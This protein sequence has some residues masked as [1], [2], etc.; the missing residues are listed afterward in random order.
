MKQRIFSTFRAFA[1]AIFIAAVSFSGAQSA[2]TATNLFSG[3]LNK[4]GVCVL[5]DCDST[6]VNDVVANS[7]YLVYARFSSKTAYDNVRVTQAALLGTRMY[8]EYCPSTAT[9]TQATVPFPTH[10]ADVLV[11]NNTTVPDA[12][13]LRATVP[14]GKFYR[15]S[16]GSGGSITATTVK[17][18]PSSMADQIGVASF[19]ND[20]E[21]KLPLM[22]RFINGPLAG[23][24]DA[25]DICQGQ[26]FA[27]QS[28]GGTKTVPDNY[29][30]SVFRSISSFN[31]QF[32]WEKDRATEWGLFSTGIPT[33]NYYL[34][35]SSNGFNGYANNS[36][37][38]YNKLGAEVYQMTM[39]NIPAD[40]V[41][42]KGAY[43]KDDKCLIVMRKSGLGN[44]T[45]TY[46]DAA[47]QEV[48]WQKD[49]DYL[50]ENILVNGDYFYY[51]SE[52][53]S[54]VGNPAGNAD[55]TDGSVG[56]WRGCASG[57][58]WISGNYIVAGNKVH[59]LSTGNL[60]TTLIDT[61][62]TYS[63]GIAASVGKVYTGSG[64]D[65]RQLLSLANGA[66][67]DTGVWSQDWCGG[68][69]VSP[70][71]VFGQS[72]RP[73]SFETAA[74]NSVPNFDQKS[75]CWQ[76]VILGNGGAF[77][78]DF[79]CSCQRSFEGFLSLT[80]GDD[81][82]DFSYDPPSSEKLFQETNFSTISSPLEVLATD[83]STYRQNVSRSGATVAN[84]GTSVDITQR[85]IGT[86]MQGAEPTAPVTAGDFVFVADDKGRVVAYSATSGSVVWSTAVSGAVR[87]SPTVWDGRLYIGS[88]DGFAYC[89]EA[90]TG[91]LLW[92]FMAGPRNRKIMAYDKL[93]S[94]WP[95]NTGIVVLEPAATGL[96]VPAA[97]FVAGR[98]F[99]DGVYAYAVN[100]LTGEQL[101]RQDGLGVV[102]G[103]TGSEAM[104]V[105][106]IV[107]VGQGY[108][109]VSGATQG[110]GYYAAM[111]LATGA[112]KKNMRT[113][114][115]P[116]GHFAGFFKNKYM[117]AGARS[118]Y[119][120]QD[121][122][123]GGYAR[124]WSIWSKATNGVTDVPVG[125]TYSQLPAAWDDTLTLVTYSGS[126]HWFDAL[127][128]TLFETS[129]DTATASGPIQ[130]TGW[131]TWNATATTRAWATPKVVTHCRGY[132]LAGDVAIAVGNKSTAKEN[133]AGITYK[134][135]PDF[136]FTERSD[137]YLFT[138]D[139]VTGAPLNEVALPGE[140]L[141]NGLAVD[142]SGNIVISFLDGKIGLYKPQA[143][144]N[145]PLVVNAGTGSGTYL[146]SSA[147]TITAAAPPVGMEFDQWTGD[148]GCLADKYSSTTTLLLPRAATAVTA[149]Y[150]ATG[151]TYAITVSGGTGGGSFP[152]GSAPAIAAAAPVAGKL[153]QK[154]TVS[155]NGSCMDP[156]AS[157][158]QFVVGAGNATVTATYA[159]VIPSDTQSFFVDFGPVITP[160][161][162]GVRWNNVTDGNTGVKVANLLDSQGTSS[163]LSLSLSGNWETTSDYQDGS[164]AGTLIYPVSVLN[165]YIAARYQMSSTTW[166]G[167]ITLSNLALEQYNIKVYYSFPK[168]GKGVLTWAGSN[169][170]TGNC[171]GAIQ[172]AAT[173][174][175]STVT[176][177]YL[178]EFNGV[179]PATTG[180][181]FDVDVFSA[182][183]GSVAG[184]N[185]MEVTKVSD[186]TWKLLIDFGSNPSPAPATD[187]NYWN[188]LS[189]EVVKINSAV[190]SDNSASGVKLEIPYYWHLNQNGSTTNTAY[191]DNA[192]SD[193]ITTRFMFT[194]GYPNYTVHKDPGVVSLS[195]LSA[196]K[197]YDFKIYTLGGWYTGNIKSV[198]SGTTPVGTVSHYGQDWL[199]ANVDG[200]VGSVD[201]SIDTTTDTSRGAIAVMEIISKPP[202]DVSAPAFESG[203]PYAME[204]TA[205]SVRIVVKGNESGTVY[206][207]VR[208]AGDSV[209]KPMTGEETRNASTG[210]FALSPYET[211]VQISGLVPEKA[212]EICLVAEDAAETPNLQAS[213]TAVPVTTLA[214][215]ALTVNN[216]RGSGTYAAGAGVRIIANKGVTGKVFDH[217]SASAGTLAD[218]N[219]S[220]TTFV[221]PGS[222]ASVTPVYR[223]ATT[224]TVSVNGG[225]GGGVYTEG[226]MIGI[227]AAP[228]A[229]GKVFDQW[230]GDVSG[231]DVYS[232]NIAVP[233]SSSRNL[234]ATY[235]D[236]K[237]RVDFG[238]ATL[239]STR[240][241]NNI[242][243][244]QTAAW[245]LLDNGENAS[246]HT[247][248]T[249]YTSTTGWYSLGNSGLNPAVEVHFPDSASKD[250]FQTQGAD[251]AKGTGT[252]VI[253][254]FD[255]SKIYDF[256]VY[257]CS[258]DSTY[259]RNTVVSV[260]GSTQNIN[261]K[262]NLNTVLTFTGITPVNGV[263]TITMTPQEST[264]GTP[265]WKVYMN[266]LEFYETPDS[267]APA[268]ASAPAV[269]P[270]S[271]SA[272]VTLS[273]NE[274][275]IVSYALFASG[276]AAPTPAAVKAGTGALVIG[277]FA[278][279]KNIADTFALT[280]L[281]SNTHYDLYLVAED[282]WGN[283]QG[284]VTKVSFQT[285]FPAPTVAATNV[286][287]SSIT[288]SSLTANWTRG[289]GARCLVVIRQ[290]GDVTA[291]L[292]V[293]GQSYTASQ[294]WASKGSNLGNGCYAIYDGT[295][296]SVSLTG[297]DNPGAV[298]MVT[299]Y[300]YNGVGSLANYLTVDA[301]TASGAMAPG[302]A[303]V[304]Q[305]AS[306]VDAGGNVTLSVS[307]V[308]GNTYQWYQG[309]SG[310][311]S[312][313]VSGATAASYTTP[314]L[315]ADASYWVKVTTVGGTANS[316]TAF[317][318]VK[319]PVWVAYHATYSGA[320]SANTTVG[321]YEVATVFNLKRS[322]N[323]ATNNATIQYTR[324][325]GTLMARTDCVAGPSSGTDAY[326]LFNGKVVVGP[327]AN[328]VSNV[329]KTDIVIAGLSSSKR[330][331]LAIYATRDASNVTAKNKYTL[332][333]VNAST[334]AHSA[335]CT[336][337]T[338]GVWS[339]PTG[340]GS[341]T[342]GRLIR[343]TGIQ[344]TSDRISVAVQAD[345]SPNYTVPQAISITEEYTAPA[346]AAISAQPVGS[347]IASGTTASMSVTATGTGLQYQWFEGTSGDTAHPVA[348][349]MSASLTTPA[350]S[351]TTS[352]WV[353]VLNAGGSVD[354]AAAT[355]AVAS[356]TGY[357]AWVATHSLAGGNALLSAS[358]AGDGVTNLV[359][360]ALG[361]APDAAA[362]Q[363]LPY[364]EV[365]G[366]N[367]TL[368]FRKGKTVPGSWQYIVQSS[369]NLTV[370]ND[371]MVA[372]AAAITA[373]A[374]ASD[375]DSDTYKASIPLSNGSGGKLFLRLK[376]IAP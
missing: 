258:Y 372:T 7:D 255:D 329:G 34:H 230:T 20:W 77:Y 42:Y 172:T 30:P 110:K 300:E 127:D 375:A 323:G 183:S 365:E 10:Y 9:S 4:R 178:M 333:T 351:A 92:K 96:G 163:A 59:A 100:A 206:Y 229:Y 240:G 103:Y 285:T 155:G 355:V 149:T 106:T 347:S 210:S 354:S 252:I 279:T 41:F 16:G 217:W 152:V 179:T 70:R 139:K 305:T 122:L 368:R 225:S 187:G 157:T 184:I 165:D 56:G 341:Q 339:V 135:A 105:N 48:I 101:W 115:S 320:H 72:G 39:P 324:T 353:R 331:T 185:A 168:L 83:W 374:V 370:W 334:P 304:A 37:R 161:T 143:R 213:P 156:F 264:G 130:A 345:G 78:P 123:S 371:E 233:A 364:T 174:T 207:N 173:P 367:L 282:R 133:S 234:T 284:A 243:A 358:P 28:F 109:W 89:F 74:W 160:T 291:S 19:S 119:Q 108:L 1:V 46:F 80:G 58:Q 307:S 226:D 303:F 373:G 36:L 175:A 336:D 363:K 349:A 194:E 272:Q 196:G 170:V 200:A 276:A 65:E 286:V 294:D 266:A 221:M 209:S 2:V 361:M 360:F 198:K 169:E 55:P 49:S 71:L 290:N 273:S 180:A 86:A 154:W 3:I 112:L 93:T 134:S 13:G 322:D 5:I 269:N 245:N 205:T 182:I 236:Q 113:E 306:S 82:H 192:E 212:Y 121:K 350:L 62:S 181:K 27:K 25:V 190:L 288:E 151:T 270:S 251:Q 32:L 277:N 67:T 43:Y 263:V 144:I 140:P 35:F 60:I 76:G 257:T 202:T 335:G 31:G 114:R 215:Y 73:Y 79:S 211:S 214:S 287:L 338:G 128:T 87:I 23:T 204:V 357:E 176:N 309:I 75:P 242:N 177:G 366:A 332:T 47:T 314:A 295:G 250:Y 147:V 171:K 125:W 102:Q 247:L 66:A 267:T 107:T 244:K 84:V 327:T 254:G 256:K 342:A 129:L 311:E 325:G 68:S 21:I 352:Y 289:N 238:S 292:P 51:G 312:T 253:G 222:I 310:D 308:P 54:L 319:S 362:P 142:R 69:S 283:L 299:V 61:P 297:L 90:A 278:V 219:S 8:A 50:I 195:G 138:Y 249:P 11:V 81:G 208:E 191:P 64:A 188:N 117:V 15:I 88:E 262:N 44:S 63:G 237:V 246:A 348:G 369:S 158:T 316:T 326:N 145:I 124:Y 224:Y 313:P 120:D 218:A 159:D 148:V 260:N 104:N 359:K 344:P 52:R 315:Q 193:S 38:V 302:A 340:T 98:A 150:I 241:W 293:G 223:D 85:W 111:N 94:T 153:F 321:G 26:L 261:A 162:S 137:Y 53:Y 298:W 18:F 132:V 318:Y 281:S 265:Y 227:A 228:A 280:E 376:V 29:L 99:W 116:V 239:T 356:V 201:I 317:V 141:F 136:G 166:E 231:I 164:T 57:S 131:H 337:L 330:Y 14:H 33:K 275:G 6:L 220:T 343:W 22:T 259:E 17:P 199:V 296:N 235:M 346:T 186:P 301:P 328:M 232:A 167:R 45:L 146:S 248:L 91:R 97:Y 118:L 95:V 40:F 197:R 126:Y 216:G 274:T 271:T 268:W 189:R 24:R 12:E 203:Y